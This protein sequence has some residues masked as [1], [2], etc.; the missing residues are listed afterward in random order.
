[1]GK[2]LVAAS[3][4]DGDQA[5][6]WDVATGRRVKALRTNGY[7]AQLA[8]SPDGKQLAAAAGPGDLGTLWDVANGKEL[9]TFKGK[10]IAFTAD[11]KLLISTWG[12]SEKTTVRSY[13]TTDGKE[14]AEWSLAHPRPGDFT[15]SADGQFAAAPNDGDKP[16]ISVF[17]LG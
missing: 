17:D 11:G 6:F 7:I 8:F 4:N 5:V 16:S 9:C 12:V 14:Q 13:A 2:Y 15:L 10:E 3:R 1:D